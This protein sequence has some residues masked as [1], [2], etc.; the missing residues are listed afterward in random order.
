MPQHLV[1]IHPLLRVFAQGGRHEVAEVSCRGSLWWE[2]DILLN[3]L[4]QVGALLDIE[5]EPP[6]VKFVGEHPDGPEVMLSVIG[7]PLEQFRR[8]IQGSPTKCL[9]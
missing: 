8:S 3:D 2:F 9:S 1:A 4:S 6:I 7:L 5:G